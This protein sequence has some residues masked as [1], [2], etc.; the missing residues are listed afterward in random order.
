MRNRPPARRIRSRSENPVPN[1]VKRAASQENQVAQRKPCTEQREERGSEAYDP[2]DRE[3]ENDAKDERQ[4]EAELAR[5]L[6]LGGRQF[7]G[8]DREE[9][10][11][12]D[13][14]HDL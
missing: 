11:I 1:S 8:D 6:C 2:E 7:L 14:Q 10:H 12:V 13:A 4:G 9:D 5:P 3:Q